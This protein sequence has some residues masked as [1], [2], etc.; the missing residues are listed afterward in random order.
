MLETPDSPNGKQD[1]QPPKIDTLKRF[2][3]D[4]TQ[5][6]EDC[7]GLILILDSPSKGPIVSSS[8]I[9]DRVLS[10]GMMAMGQKV[11]DQHWAMQNL[12]M[13]KQQAQSQA[14]QQQILNPNQ[15]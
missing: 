1:E 2:G 12:A 11:L 14:L 8:T 9:N 10:L 6:P 13:Q 7:R 3:I 15:M 4:V 5:I